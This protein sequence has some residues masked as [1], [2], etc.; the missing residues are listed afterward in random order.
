MMK[1]SLLLMCFCGCPL[2]LGACD[3]AD[4]KDEAYGRLIYEVLPDTARGGSQDPDDPESIYR[5]FVLSSAWVNG[6]QVEYLDLGPVNPVLPSVYVMVRGGK[7]VAGQY[8]IIDTL[9]N[10][11]DYS[12]FW[13][14]VEVTVPGSYA[15]NDVKSLS[16]IK[17]NGYSMKARAEAMYCPVINPDA[18]WI[19]SDGYTYLTDAIYD[20]PNPET[21]CDDALLPP[22]LNVFY[23]TGEE[24][25]NKDPDFVPASG[26]E[27]GTP[28]IPATLAESAATEQDIR[29]QPVWHKRLLGFCWPGMT[30]AARAKRYPVTTTGGVA[31]LNSDAFAVRYDFVLPEPDPDTGEL[32]P[33]DW[34][35]LLDTTL[36]N[37]ADTPAR[38]A[39]VLATPVVEEGMDPPEA[40]TSLAGLDLTAAEPVGLVDN[41]IVRAVPVPAAST[42]TDGAE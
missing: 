27:P 11:E 10:Q 8:P 15:A 13:Q 24:I 39:F 4:T 26:E 12:S 42:C 5:Q 21:D 40:P 22:A 2:F 18:A 29:L 9:P 14:V 28:D 33:A 36:G 38:N 37:A 3:D 32:V 23:G 1:S 31:E 16:S 30:N 7:P 25:P 20:D 34:P 6:D 17:K 41:P 19:A 35:T